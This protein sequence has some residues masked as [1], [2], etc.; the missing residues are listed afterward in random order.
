MQFLIAFFF[1]FRFSVR[2]RITV[3]MDLICS[4]HEKLFLLSGEAKVK[5][6]KQLIALDAQIHFCQE[7]VLQVNSHHP[8]SFDDQY[9]PITQPFLQ[10]YYHTIRRLI[11]TWYISLF[12]YF[13]YS[14][15]FRFHSQVLES[16]SVTTI[17]NPPIINDVL[18]GVHAEENTSHLSIVVFGASGDLAKKKT[19]WVRRKG[20]N[21]CDFKY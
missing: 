7:P 15:L 18:S 19:M 11:L 20:P 13:L 10:P 2:D 12:L 6:W 9:S 17:S 3:S 14:R 21:L 1:T 5:K 4:S 16:H 8:H